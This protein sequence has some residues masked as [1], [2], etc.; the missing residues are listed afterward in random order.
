[1]YPRFIFQY[2][3]NSFKTFLVV[4]FWRSVTNPTTDGLGRSKK[5]LPSVS[6]ETLRAKRIFIIIHFALTHILFSNI[7]ITTSNRY[8]LYCL[9]L[10]REKRYDDQIPIKARDI[11]WLVTIPTS[12]IMSQWIWCRYLCFRAFIKRIKFSVGIHFLEKV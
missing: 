10:G 1:M 12:N 5:P 9:G 6:D 2:T 4:T 3:N 8:V 7:Y 11:L